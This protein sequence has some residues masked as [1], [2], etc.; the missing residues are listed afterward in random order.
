MLREW[1]ESSKT[2]GVSQ[3]YLEKYVRNVPDHQAYLELIGTERLDKAK[4]RR[5]VR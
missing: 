1:D 2:A 5:E 4:G 3:T